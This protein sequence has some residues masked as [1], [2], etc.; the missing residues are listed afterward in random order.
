M[1]ILVLG[2]RI[3]GPG[4][5]NITGKSNKTGK[6]RL[7]SNTLNMCYVWL[8]ERVGDSGVYAGEWGS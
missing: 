8:K 5:S 3:Y 6:S 7:D 1:Y 2:E 4:K